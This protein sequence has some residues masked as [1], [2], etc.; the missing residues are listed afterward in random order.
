M[1]SCW[2]QVIDKKNEEDS[3]QI[4]KE[5]RKSHKYFSNDATLSNRR[6]IFI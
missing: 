5:K 2:I 6:S 1:I 4:A 3:K